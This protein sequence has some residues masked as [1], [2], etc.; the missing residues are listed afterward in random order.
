MT[1]ERR[2]FYVATTRAKRELVILNGGNCQ[3]VPEFQNVPLTKEDIEY[4][5]REELAVQEPKLKKKLEETAK[6]A[7]VGFQYTLK[8]KLAKA[9][10]TERKQNE[11][12]LNRLRGNITQAQ[13]ATSELETKL[14][15]ALK[16]AN[17]NLFEDLIPVLDEFEGLFKNLPE[18]DQSNNTTDY[19]SLVENVQLAQK[20][21]C[22]F[23]ENHGLK[24]IEVSQGEIFNPTYHEEISSAIYSDGVPT[25]RIARSERRG[26]LLHNQVVRKAQVVISKK[27]QKADVL[28]SR[29]FAQPVRFGTY[30]GF[31]DLRN[32]EVFKD[33]VKGFNSQGREIQLQALNTL[34]AFPKEG[35]ASLK[36]HIKIR[37]PIANQNLQP[38]E[39]ISERFHI[40][41][42]IL[43]SFL[44]KRDALEFDDQDPTVE[45]VTRSGHVLNGHLSDFDEDFLYMHISKKTVIVY[46]GG[47]LKLTN[48]TWA[49]IR[50]AYRNGTT[51][52][53]HIIARRTRGFAVR[54]QLLDGFLPEP[55]V[56]LQR[57]G[58]LDSYVGKILEMKV[59]QIS[60]F[61]NKVVFSHR[62]WLVERRTQLLNTL[63]VGQTIMGTVKN[64][65]DFGAFVDLGGIDGLLHKSEIAWRRI[66]HPSEVVSV[67]E[68]IEVKVIEF[69]RENKKIS[70]SLKQLTNDPWENAEEKYPVGSKIR[71]IV[72]NV[73][74][75]GAFIQLEEGIDGLI[76]IS[77]MPTNSRDVLASDILNK[78]D[79]VEVTVIRI[80]K[81]SR[82]ISLRMIADPPIPVEYPPPDLPMPT[83]KIKRMFP[84]NPPD[85]MTIKSTEDA[86]DTPPV[87]EES[88]FDGE[89]NATAPCE[90][91]STTD[92]QPVEE[93]VDRLHPMSEDFSEILKPEIQN[94]KP[95]TLETEVPNQSP[96]AVNNNSDPMSQKSKEILKEQI[97]NLKPALPEGNTGTSIETTNNILNQSTE[98]VD[99]EPPKKMSNS[100]LSI[101]TSHEEVQKDES[102]D[103]Q[104]KLEHHLRKFGRFVL[105]KLKQK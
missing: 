20:Q 100:S 79:E 58:N 76:H 57:V 4:A 67:G 40:A 41:D 62:A 13:N 5:F 105:R 81:D 37:R 93:T 102:Q 103:Q 59:T 50:R 56:A 11:V 19:T 33:E 92:I 7:L 101:E 63:K 1:E 27:K 24:P 99:S 42:D 10:D 95:A 32:I 34:F 23:L 46:R 44:I 3:F 66:D 88:S 87:P 78:D 91:I 45:C 54:C 80:S 70:L 96:E 55:E 52:S 82:R 29:D 2:L 90:P 6:A 85:S 68:D 21:L 15:I 71:G 48:L 104:R 36:S 86:E 72:T 30:T 8:Q 14:P 38:I 69:D 60:T 9:S 26:R 74:H 83:E 97:E 77:E 12:K 65:R 89:T 43:K 31:C 17:K 73:V 98:P 51:I 39:F 94:L 49:K 84:N 47:I 16:A 64:I 61:G 35:M 53:G 28:L 75:Y 22:A 25:G 18:T